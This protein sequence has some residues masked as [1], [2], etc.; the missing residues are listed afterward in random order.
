MPELSNIH[1]GE[2]LLEEFMKP[3]ALSAE[4]LAS[5]MAMPR[6][7]IEQLLEGRRDIDLEWAVGLAL[8]FGTS[9]QF[10]LSLQFEYDSERATH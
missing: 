6:C 10:W 5:F 4:H 2:I 3:K 1:P 7:S 9:A 8:M